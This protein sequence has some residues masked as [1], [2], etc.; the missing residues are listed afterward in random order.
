MIQE[1]A[2][3]IKQNWLTESYSEE[4]ERDILYYATVAIYG[5]GFNGLNGAHKKYAEPIWP[6]VKILT[7]GGCHKISKNRRCGGLM[8]RFL[9]TK[10]V[11]P[12]FKSRPRASAQ[13]SLSGSRLCCE[14]CVNKV[15]KHKAQVGSK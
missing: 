4:K 11:R 1:T 14:Y 3:R 15:L 6:T 13:C 7:R 12:G 10:S 5:K 2:G 9:A 8:A